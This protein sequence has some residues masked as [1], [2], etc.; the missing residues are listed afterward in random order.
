MLISECNLSVGQQAVANILRKMQHTYVS[1]LNFGLAKDLSLVVPAG[2]LYSPI[3]INIV[4][5]AI[6]FNYRSLLKG[7]HPPHLNQMMGLILRRIFH[8]KLLITNVLL[9]HNMNAELSS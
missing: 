3:V 1:R 7:Q 5:I 6:N 9:K 4:Y 2:T 8:C